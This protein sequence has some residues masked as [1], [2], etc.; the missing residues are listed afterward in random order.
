[1]LAAQ[2]AIRSAEVGET[3]EECAV[4][5]VWEETGL[6][7]TLGVELPRVRY[8]DRKDRFKEV[9]Y[10]SMEPV[11]GELHAG[12]DEVDIVRWVSVAYAHELLSRVQDREVVAAWVVGMCDGCGNRGSD[13]GK[14]AD[15][16]RR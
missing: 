2:V 4:R 6:R 11:D 5:E 9:R 7:C 14:P 16:A 10:W 8:R 13:A 1:M 15:S 12:N 3:D